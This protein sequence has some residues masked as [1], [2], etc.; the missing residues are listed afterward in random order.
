LKPGTPLRPDTIADQL[1][2]ST[3]PVREALLSLESDGALIKRPYQGWFVR[4]FSEEEARE[5]YELRASLEC[6]S[7]RL[8]CERI[9]PEEVNRLRMHQAAGSAAL[10][11]KNIHAYRL[12]NQ[13]LHTAILQA[14]RNS[15]L[16]SAMEQV[17]LQNQMLIARTIRITGRPSRALEEHARI[18]ELIASRDSTTA[19]DLMRKHILSALEDVVQA[20]GQVPHKAD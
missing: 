20:L 3:T 7:V 10:A 5:M 1:Q 11:S 17:S 15:Y 18:I 6:L 16:G 19:E 12:Y 2:V 8:A 9:T 4:D 14:A 13:D